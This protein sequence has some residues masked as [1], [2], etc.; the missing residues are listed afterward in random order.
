MTNCIRTLL[1]K[2]DM[3]GYVGFDGMSSTKSYVDP[4]RIYQER[5]SANDDCGWTGQ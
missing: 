1:N 2:Q 3:R 4:T 5:L